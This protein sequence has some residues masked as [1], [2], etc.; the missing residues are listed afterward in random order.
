MTLNAGLIMGL[1]GIVL[2]VRQVGR[3]HWWTGQAARL[4]SARYVEGIGDL[5]SQAV[6]FGSVALIQFGNVADHMRE[7][8]LPASLWLSFVGS[9]IWFV[10][11]GVAVGR[12]LMRWQLRS[13]LA[14]IDAEDARS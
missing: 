1:A 12:V 3:R 7:K 14:A 5:A 10:M 9:T 8:T 11:F 2:M 6:L 4:R 13:L